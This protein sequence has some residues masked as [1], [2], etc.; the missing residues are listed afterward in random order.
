MVSAVGLAVGRGMHHIETK[1][2][3]FWR[4]P[5]YPSYLSLFYRLYGITNP[6]FNA[7]TSAQKASIWFQILLCS[8]VPLLLFFLA[9]L[10]T[11]SLAIAWITGLIFAF[12]FGFILSGCYLLT[13]ALASVFFTLFL[14]LFYRGFSFIG[15]PKKSPKNILLFIA[16]AACMLGLYTWFRP[17]GEFVALLALFILAFC[18]CP[19]QRKLLKMTV[20]AITFFVCIFPWYMRNH[21]LT[22]NWFFCPMS[23]PYLMAFSAPKIVRRIS[24]RPL[25]QCLKFLFAKMKRALEQEQALAKVVSPNKIMC[26]ELMCGRVAWPWIKKYP[27]YFLIDWGKEVCK[28]TFD[29]YGSQLVAFTNNSFKFDPI[30]EFLTEKLKLCIYKQSMPF[31]MRLLCWLELL[32]SL[33]VWIGLFGG[34][35]LFLL[36]PLLQKNN[37]INQVTTVLWIKCGLLIGGL[38]MQ[39]GGFGYARLRMPIE[40]LMII[41]SLTFWYWLFTSRLKDQPS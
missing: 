1:K 14:I 11:K 33:L 9:L 36:A 26:Q 8:L 13:D 41:L 28:T 31:I 10:L 25:D 35:W 32:F 2:P 7:N 22:G 5:G 27:G 24:E 3:I 4:T 29:L 30:E 34:L 21:E 38:I 17:H 15:E 18:T 40:P 23:G 19:W 12:H 6:Q 20:F 16:L 37:L 39:T